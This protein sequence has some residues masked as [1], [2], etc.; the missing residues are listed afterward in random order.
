MVHVFSCWLDM[1]AKSICVF[2]MWCVYVYMFVCVQNTAIIKK[3]EKI[4]HVFL[5]RADNVL[6]NHIQT[7]SIPVAI[8]VM[9][10]SQWEWQGEEN[11]GGVG[12]KG[13]CSGCSS[14]L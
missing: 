9:L 12:I 5:K 8:Y 1:S 11:Q 13:V 4:H 14:C 6:Y 10:V 2:C 3:V 7:F